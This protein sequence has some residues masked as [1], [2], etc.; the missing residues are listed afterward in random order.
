[1]P[2]NLAIDDTLIKEA[3][4][5]GGHRTKKAAVTIA[6]QEYIQ[7]HR[8]QQITEL[9]GTIDYAPDY[10]YKKHRH[11]AKHEKHQGSD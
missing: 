3:V 9:F 7:H 1:M 8:Q 11:R 6:L 5:V 2:T 4:T 10:N